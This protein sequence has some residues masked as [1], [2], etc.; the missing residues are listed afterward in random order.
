M[1]AT[2]ELS[3]GVRFKVDVGEVR[4][5]GTLAH[6]VAHA[7]ARRGWWRGRILAAMNAEFVGDWKVAP[8]AHPR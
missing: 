2:G 5:D 1:A 8:R 7:I 6:F 3:S 4:H